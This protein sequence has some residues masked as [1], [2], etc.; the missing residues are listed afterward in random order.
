MSPNNWRISASQIAL[1]PLFCNVLTENIAD[2]YKYK[3]KKYKTYM[4]AV[5][6]ISGRDRGYIPN[7]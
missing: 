2:L 6:Y 7:V 3:Y 5:V 4:F 1:I